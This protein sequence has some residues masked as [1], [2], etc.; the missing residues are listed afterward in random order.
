ML[1]IFPVVIVDYTVLD[2]TNF[3][4]PIPSSMI[5]EITVDFLSINRAK[6]K[7]RE[8]IKILTKNN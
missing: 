3:G 8:M 2:G 1:E 7:T 6:F 5:V 4:R